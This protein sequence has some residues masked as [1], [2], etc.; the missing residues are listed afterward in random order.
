MDIG[1]GASLHFEVN[2]VTTRPRRTC[3]G[4]PSAC[5][6][7]DLKFFFLN[8]APILWSLSVP[9]LANAGPDC[10]PCGGHLNIIMRIF[11]NY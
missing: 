6:I 8:D 11:K 2:F 3:C 5:P 1:L 10:D 7:T 4:A 9:A